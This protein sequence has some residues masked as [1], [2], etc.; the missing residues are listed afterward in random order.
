MTF[1]SLHLLAKSF[2]YPPSYPY[3][4]LPLI[5]KPPPKK[6]KHTPTPTPSPTATPSPT[7]SPSP[8]P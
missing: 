1:L 6:H 4:D 2:V 3:F 8:A 7:P 5:Y